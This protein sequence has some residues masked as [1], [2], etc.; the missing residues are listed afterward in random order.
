MALVSEELGTLQLNL[1][2]LPG[3]NLIVQLMKEQEGVVRQLKINQEGKYEFKS[4]DPGKYRI[5]I[6]NDRNNNGRWDTGNYERKQSPEQMYYFSG[7]ISV[8]ANWE[9]EQEW[10]V[11]R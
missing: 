8:R 3:G 5:A 1:S 11:V 4:L 2:N 9:L 10:N 6:L 7:D